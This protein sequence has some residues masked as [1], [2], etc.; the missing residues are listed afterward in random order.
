MLT[1]VKNLLSF[2][3]TGQN[4][5]G[6][7]QQQPLSLSLV[8]RKNNEEER[9][10]KQ[11]MESTC[12]QVGGCGTLSLSGDRSN[13]HFYFSIFLRVRKRLNSFGCCC[14]WLLAASRFL[15]FATA[16]LPPQRRGVY[17]TRNSD[18]LRRI[19]RKEVI[20]GGKPK[21]KKSGQ[22][23]AVQFFY[24]KKKIKILHSS[25]S[26]QLLLF[27]S[28]EEEETKIFTHTTAEETS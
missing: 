15:F 19:E 9:A 26:Q 27:C 17:L 28:H 13:T 6:Q 10:L 25:P 4:P 12:A 14:C 16:R 1:Q 18:H 20:F 22:C 8:S 11:L 21:K 7:Q 5:L 3:K 23:Q 24:L 2:S